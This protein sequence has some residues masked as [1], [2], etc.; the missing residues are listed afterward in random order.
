[1]APTVLKKKKKMK[2]GKKKIFFQE[3]FI[4]DP[5]FLIL[6]IF[7]IPLINDEMK[8]ST[9]FG[10]GS[11]A[12]FLFPIDEIRFQLKE[13][14]KQI[15]IQDCI[16][17]TTFKSKKKTLQEIE[18][19]IDLIFNY[20]NISN[21]YIASLES[22]VE[23]IDYNILKISSNNKNVQKIFLVRNDD[24]YF[25]TTTIFRECNRKGSQQ[26]Y[27]SLHLELENH[28]IINIV[29]KITLSLQNLLLLYSKKTNDYHNNVTDQL[30]SND[31]AKQRNVIKKII[32][33]IGTL[34]KNNA[35]NTS[36]LMESNNFFILFL[37]D[38]CFL[39]CECLLYHMSLVKN[40]L[41]YKC[42]KFRE[43]IVEDC[44]KII[45]KH[46]LIDN[47][48]CINFV[49]YTMKNIINTYENY[50]IICVLEMQ[51]I[52][53]KCEQELSYKIFFNQIVLQNM[54]EETI[55]NYDNDIK[56]I[57]QLLSFGN[58]YCV[59]LEY[60]KEKINHN[61]SNENDFEVS[62]DTLKQHFN[63]LVNS[64][65]PPES[66]N[67]TPLVQENDNTYELIKK[68]FLIGKNIDNGK[69]IFGDIDFLVSDNIKFNINKLNTNKYTAYY[70]KNLFDNMF[71][72]LE[73]IN[74][75]KDKKIFTQLNN[76]NIIEYII[77]QQQKKK[78]K[79][80]LFFSKNVKPQLDIYSLLLC[81]SHNFYCND[82]YFAI[83]FDTLNLLHDNTHVVHTTNPRIE[84]FYEAYSSFTNTKFFSKSYTSVEEMDLSHLKNIHSK[85]T[86][87]K[88]SSFT[89][90]NNNNEIN[91]L[92]I[93]KALYKEGEIIL[94]KYDQNTS[95]FM[96]EYLNAIQLIKDLPKSTYTPIKEEEVDI[97]T[98]SFNNN[99]FIFDFN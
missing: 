28:K 34:K 25:N 32:N 73:T 17:R 30:E 87:Q 92:E 67:N 44:L 68:R 63:L 22:L 98:N 13:K 2:N 89:I 37:E 14:A 24:C 64:F 43:Q 9:S 18:K 85:I 72:F 15:Q 74:T 80:H 54:G 19:L 39:I 66:I 10:N 60:L 26:S 78:K 69:I 50:N 46:Y 55:I 84:T 91:V 8:I 16:T 21:K 88:L 56:D 20:V 5:I 52:N 6:N 71:D 45:E 36:V 58:N 7:E 29:A 51:N 97:K 59:F 90:I 4:L 27:N 12:V 48:K 76:H 57:I 53:L 79:K 81:E 3:N 23:N 82:F 94:P 31:I 86:T 95:L 77:Q 62:I 83:F 42:I 75:N 47:Y 41:G 61:A 99:I 93:Q 65:F 40:I 70:F 35:S 96:K 38:L 49:R 11:T 1:M 33:D